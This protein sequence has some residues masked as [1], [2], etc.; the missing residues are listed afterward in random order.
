M[1]SE[2]HIE[3]IKKQ[4]EKLDAPDFDL[5]AWKNSTVLL[6]S[7]IFGETSL[8]VSRI[9]SLSY[10]LSSWALRDTLGKTTAEEQVKRNAREMLET[11]ITEIET[12][13]PPKSEGETE[14]NPLMHAIR[15]ALE[16]ELKVSQ[17]KELGEILAETHNAEERLKRVHDFLAPFDAESLRKMLA[18]I[19]ADGETAKNF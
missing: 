16:N 5:E 15:K 11:A 17:Y 19:L 3:L 14:G 6:L 18:V 2:K 9:Q 10:H 7:R 8:I 4:I 13:G 12:L 1:E